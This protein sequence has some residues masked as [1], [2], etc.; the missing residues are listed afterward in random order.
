MADLNDA[1]FGAGRQTLTH[2]NLVEIEGSREELP[3][4]PL[5]PNIY[6]GGPYR[7]FVYNIQAGVVVDSGTL[8][9]KVS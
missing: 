3:N 9:F 8:S 5:L 6:P 4:G 2:W 7:E 1:F